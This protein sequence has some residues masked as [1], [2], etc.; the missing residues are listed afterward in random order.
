M[1]RT[2]QDTAIMLDVLAGPDRRDRHSLPREA[3]LFAEL[4]NPDVT[5]LRIAWTTD[6]GGYASTDD[7]VQAAVEA[8]AN[9]FAALGAHVEN[10]NPFSA[11]PAEAFLAIVALDFDVSAMR[12]F[13]AEHADGVNERIAGLISREWTFEEASRAFVTRRDLYNELWRFFERF[14]LLLT[15]ATPVA[16]YDV[17]LPG[18]TTIGGQPTAHGASA[19]SFTHAFNMTGNPAASIPCGWTADG[20][21]IGLQIVGNHLADR[22]VLR[23]SRAFEIA[24]P[25]IDRRPP[26]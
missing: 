21:P 14:D 3:G 16:A 13:A 26:L 7:D 8:A 6:F 20:L 11:N 18:P 23:A 2:V 5:G 24:A 9:R 1:T 10:A 12:R 17:T 22:M 19:F 25:W 15:P 4:D